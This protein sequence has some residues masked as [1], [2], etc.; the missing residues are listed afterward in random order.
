LISG[1]KDS[2]QLLTGRTAIAIVEEIGA[3][4]AFLCS[5][6]ATSIKSIPKTYRAIS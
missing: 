2:E 3:L 4:T 6:A 5:D 1:H